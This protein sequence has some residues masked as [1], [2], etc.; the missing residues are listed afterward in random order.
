MPGFSINFHAHTL[1]LSRPTV[2]RFV[3]RDYHELRDAVAENW[4]SCTR[5]DAVKLS[6][7]RPGTGNIPVLSQLAILDD[8][9]RGLGPTEIGE[10]YRVHPGTVSVLGRGTIKAG[11]SFMPEGFELI[12]Y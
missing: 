2:S 3:G 7:M 6:Q 11:L 9:K 5:D 1:G 4:L 10:A 8:L 12:R